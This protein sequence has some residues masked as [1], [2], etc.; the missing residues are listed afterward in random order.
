MMSLVLLSGLPPS[1]IR[2]LTLAE[3]TEL[4]KLRR[5]KGR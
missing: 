2:Q 4:V 5:A 3:I 1:E